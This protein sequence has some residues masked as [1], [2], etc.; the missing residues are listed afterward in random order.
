M[1]KVIRKA[2]L[3]MEQHK[4]GSLIR[5]AINIEVR[6]HDTCAPHQSIDLKPITRVFE[7]SF[8][9]E[10]KGREYGSCCGQC[11]GEIEKLWGDVPIIKELVELWK[12]WHLNTM[13]AG[14]RLQENFIRRWKT[15]H[16]DWR[17]DYSKACE[18][19]EQ[20]Y[21]YEDRDY[22]Y[23]HAWLT[24][25]IPQEVL[26]QLRELMDSI[27]GDVDDKTGQYYWIGDFD[28]LAA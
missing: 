8:T 16:P 6:Q 27:T 14:T 13:K 19:L 24:E 12:R 9:G 20:N 4:N 11:H 3:N 25:I 18:L 2:R 28:K 1:D 5:G 17:Y 15:N 7:V 21:I 23:G 10:I 26:T 22:K